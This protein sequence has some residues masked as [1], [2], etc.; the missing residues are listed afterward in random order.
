MAY[1]GLTFHIFPSLCLT[2]A[3]S[4]PWWL[5]SCLPAFLLFW[6]FGISL[7]LPNYWIQIKPLCLSFP[8]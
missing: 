1:P 3:S 6:C 5:H 8:S 7:G 4:L 2:S